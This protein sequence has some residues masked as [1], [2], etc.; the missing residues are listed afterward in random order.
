MIEDVTRGEEA[1][2]KLGEF[3][4]ALSELQSFAD[5]LSHELKAPLLTVAQ[6]NRRL[7]E[8]AAAGWTNVNRSSSV[9]FRTPV[10]R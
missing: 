5:L 2:A 10:V 9:E 4:T 1:E 3:E 6:F 7:G 8:E